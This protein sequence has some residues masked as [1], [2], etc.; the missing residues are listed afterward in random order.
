MEL[1]E[2]EREVLTRL[3]T[4]AADNGYGLNPDREAVERVV[5]G[6]VMRR[7]KKGELYCP[8]RFVTGNAETDRKIIC[9]CV[10]HAEEIA[11]DGQCHC[12]L[13]VAKKS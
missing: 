4:Y 10:Y 5:R 12:Q 3:E 8:C 9:P 13:L 11:K 2:E 6:M 7:Q 1:N